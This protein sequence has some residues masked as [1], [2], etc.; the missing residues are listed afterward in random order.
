MILQFYPA[1]R[2]PRATK[3]L[4][5][6]PSPA[7]AASR[8]PQGPDAPPQPCHTKQL[9]LML[10]QTGHT[11]AVWLTSFLTRVTQAISENSTGC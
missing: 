3:A 9:H 1:P 8:P 6:M 2:G 11:R 10:A 5:N 7:L 4:F